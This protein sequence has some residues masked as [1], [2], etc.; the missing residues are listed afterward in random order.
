[1]LLSF[2]KPHKAV[3]NQDRIQMAKN[4]KNAGIDVNI[5]RGHS[6]RTAFASNNIFI[7]SWIKIS[8]IQN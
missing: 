5:Y 2:T 6:L 3:V 7:Y 4:I 1:M 8:S